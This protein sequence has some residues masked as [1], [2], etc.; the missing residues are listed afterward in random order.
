MTANHAGNEYAARLAAQ[1][2]TPENQKVD[3]KIYYHHHNYAKFHFDLG[4]S[5][6]KTVAFANYMYITDDKREQDQLDLVADAPG[7]FIYTLKDSD[8]AAAMMQERAQE[9]ARAVLQTAV[10][11][12]AAHNQQFD[13]NAPIIPITT[14]TVTVMPV[15]PA[16]V[17]VQQV[18][19]GVAVVGVQNSF[20]GTQATEA[21]N[22]QLTTAK[23]Q[24][25]PPT[26]AD[27]AVAQLEALT[28]NLTKK[29]AATA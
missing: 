4:A 19:Q 16:A 12:A 21:V 28:A 14:P 23:S 26:A 5:N 7:T 24:T 18:P 3:A 17:Q 29:P 27:A 9:A 2:R 25:A 13:P 10:A 1:S 6:V 15:Q 22:A 8:V 20:S 11:S